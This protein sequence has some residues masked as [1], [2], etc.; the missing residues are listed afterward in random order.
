MFFEGLLSL[1]E[2]PLHTRLSRSLLFAA[3]LSL[4]AYAQGFD[5]LT[6]AKGWSRLDRDASC[7][8][9]DSATNKLYLWMKDGGVY[10]DI[11]LSQTTL[12]PERWVVD[13][14]GGAWIV[15]DTVLQYVDKT[16]KPGT[17]LELPLAVADLAWDP[18]NIFLIYKGQEI[19]VE[20]RDIRTGAVVWTYGSKPKKDTGRIHN[21]IAVN[22]DGDSVIASGPQVHTFLLDAKGKLTGQTF[23][24]LA[25]DA[26]P[27]IALNDADRGPIVWWGTK[28][29]AL[30]GVPGSQVP[31]VKMSGMLLAVLDFSAGTVTFRPTGLTEDYQLIGAS[32]TEAYFISAKG[33]IGFAPIQ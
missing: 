8:F 12:K 6:S 2:V 27:D 18:K 21:R 19:F 10:G 17:A 13:S 32:D 20:K 26:P 9:H 3:T 31:S 33:G 5:P 25:D 11:D 16:G 15:S 1:R 28:T 24:S 23:F 22:L 4:V 29:V 30:A 7:A 14:Y